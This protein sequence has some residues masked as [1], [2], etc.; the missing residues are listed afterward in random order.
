M[1]HFAATAVAARSI[2]TAALRRRIGG[3]DGDGRERGDA[4]NNFRDSFH[5]NS[6]F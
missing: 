6:P 2:V 3:T 1:L 4:Q 5:G